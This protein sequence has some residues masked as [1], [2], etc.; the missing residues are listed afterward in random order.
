MQAE[1]AFAQ[2]EDDNGERANI[3]NVLEM[4]RRCSSK[5]DYRK[6]LRS[7]IQRASDSRIVEY[8]ETV[9]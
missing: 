6:V 8:A 7:A 4:F 5:D 2:I 3:V 9:S 1:N